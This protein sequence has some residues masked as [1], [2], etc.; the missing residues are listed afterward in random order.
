MATAVLLSGGLDSAVLVAEE[1]AHDEVQPVY[2]SVGLAWEAI[3]RGAAERFLLEARLA[4]VRPLVSLSFDMTD[5]YAA[6]HWSIRGTPPGYDAPDED[7]YLPGRTIILLSKA[8]VFCAVAGIGRMAIGTLDHNPFPDA[9]TA[10]RSAL[11]HALSLGLAH[12][13]DIAAP[14][15]GT[16][17]TEVIRRGHRLALPLELTLSCM[18]P[19]VT[20]DGLARHCGDCNKCRERHE[21][22]V[23]AGIADPTDYADRTRVG[24]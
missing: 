3:E 7:V 4:R 24:G 21:A 6:A 2:V 11:A 16:S 12:P 5:V 8:S 20:A 23:N 1:A 22:F 13:I 9:T 18:Q 19:T 10:F 17:K 14:Y 15:A